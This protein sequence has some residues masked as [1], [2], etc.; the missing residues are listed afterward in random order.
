MPNMTM[1]AP[2]STTTGTAS[3][4]A[5]IFGSKPSATIMRPPVAV[6]Q[7][8]RTPVTPTRPT[9]CEKDV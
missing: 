8:D 7:R 2:P 3:T 9:F 6:T 1:P 4:R 5:D